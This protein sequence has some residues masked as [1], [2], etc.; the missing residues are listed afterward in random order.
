MVRAV[1]MVAMVGAILAGVDK[2]ATAVAAAPTYTILD[3]GTLGGT[4]AEAYDVNNNRETSG[5]AATAS[6][7]TGIWFHWRSGVMTGGS[8]ASQVSSGLAVNDIGHVVG[9]IAPAAGSTSAAFAFDTHRFRLLPGLGGTCDRANDV[10][11]KDE[12]VGSSY[13]SGDCATG[14]HHLAVVWI[15]RK[16]HSLSSLI[17]PTGNSSAAAINFKEMIT[18]TSDSAAGH[19]HAFFWRAG[20]MWDSGVLSGAVSSAGL[21][22]NAIGDTVG[23][24]TFPGGSY[25]AYFKGRK[26]KTMIDLGTLGGADSIAYGIGRSDEVV[27]TAQVAGNADHAFVWASGVMTDLNSRINAGS[28]WLLQA[29][30]A[31]NDYG[32]ISGYGTFG[33]HV[34]AFL[35]VPK[36]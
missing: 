5:Q 28:G 31:M 33:G 25:H 35:L 9:V 18:G 13:V 10:N 29:A 12:V 22:I 21:D 4:T 16:P 36:R 27:G 30:T 26:A 32:V 14:T 6:N 2:A 8:Q 7:A 11:N 24:S 20:K 34:Q 1:A 15:A 19:P 23:E 17:G 3:L